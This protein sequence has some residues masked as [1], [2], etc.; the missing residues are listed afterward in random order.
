MLNETC[1]RHPYSKGFCE[2]DDTLYFLLHFSQCEAN[3]STGPNK[4]NSY[5]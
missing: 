2:H 5:K 4:I 3:A 1:K